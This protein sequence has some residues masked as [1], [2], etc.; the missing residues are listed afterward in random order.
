MDKKCIVCG[1]DN[2]LEETSPLCF[3]CVYGLPA[4]LGYKIIALHHTYRDAIADALH[5]RDT[6][7]IRIRTRQTLP[8]CVNSEAQQETETQN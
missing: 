2:E 3:K 6:Q 8:E 1:I 7:K 4:R 5:W